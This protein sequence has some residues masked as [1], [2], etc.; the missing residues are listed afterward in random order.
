MSNTIPLTGR[1][2]REL[3][4]FDQHYTQEAAQGI[5]PLSDFDKHRYTNPPAN[6]I[7]PREYYYHLLAPLYGKDVLEIACGNGIDASICAHNG[8]NHHAYDLSEKSI[9][10]TR[11]RAE[12]NG[13]SDRLNLTTCGNFADAFSSQKF[14][15][16]IGYAALHHI[17][18]NGLSEM[19]YERLNPG[20]IAVFAEPV[21]NSK[22]LNRVRRCIPIHPADPTE[23]EAP[24]NNQQIDEFAKP[25][26]RIVR[27]EFQLVSRIWPLFPNN[28][29]LAVTLHWLDYY[30]L[31]FP[32]MRSLASLVVFGVYRD[33]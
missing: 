26:D 11:R 3:E 10:M 27:R 2:A 33:R 14:D 13:V 16:I 5:E 30:L 23:D 1:L 32:P 12:T 21:V 19:I 28:W 8:T 6:T 20:G 22:L 25:F 18:M 29:S 7:Y 15:C 31:K 24:L 9:E 17:P 4:H